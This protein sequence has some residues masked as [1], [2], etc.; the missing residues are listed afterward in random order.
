MLL[1]VIDT[2][3]TGL[4]PQR[5][6]M[7]EL[8]AVVMPTLATISGEN[9]SMK[10][11]VPRD[12]LVAG[13]AKKINKIPLGQRNMINN[14]LFVDDRQSALIE[15][16]DFCDKIK[17]KYG[18]SF[19]F[20]GW[21]TPFDI[22]FLKASYERE[23]IEYDFPWRIFDTVPYFS[24]YQMQKSDMPEMDLPSGLF[25][26]ARNM[27]VAVED[28]QEHSALGDAIA[29]AR[30]IRAIT[31]ELRSN[32]GANYEAFTEGDSE[33]EENPQDGAKEKPRSLS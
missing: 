19:Y 7:L 11:S 23:N 3:T 9:F 13:M 6:V 25:K 24:A 21:Q 30:V 27:N 29:T 14:H 20:A 26:V 1:I 8:G 31:E 4:D 15:F 17:T 33:D 10:L 32:A 22:D 5:N 28:L 18:E 2:E 16:W 12:A